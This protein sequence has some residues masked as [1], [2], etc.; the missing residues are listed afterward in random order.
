MVSWEVDYSALSRGTDDG[1]LGGL[2]LLICLRNPAIPHYPWAR[3]SSVS[4]Q[5][6]Q[7]EARVDDQ[8]RNTPTYDGF[9][10]FTEQTLIY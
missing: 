1:I 7:K 3:I 4:L 5:F 9:L 8:E 10:H 6:N 2:K